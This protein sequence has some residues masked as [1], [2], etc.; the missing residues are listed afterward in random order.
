L[1]IVGR[2]IQPQI[3]Q[4]NREFLDI[5][6]VVPTGQAGGGQPLKKERKEKRFL[7]GEI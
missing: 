4:I 7:N 5:V 6:C 3:A 2:E 1:F